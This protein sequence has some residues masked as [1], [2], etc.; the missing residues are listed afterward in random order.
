M[1]L[2]QQVTSLDL[3]KRLKELGVKQESLFFWVSKMRHEN[4]GEGFKRT[5]DVWVIERFGEVNPSG[6]GHK[7]ASA[8]T[9]AELGEVLPQGITTYCTNITGKWGWKSFYI[10][11]TAISLDEKFDTEADARAKMLICLL[12]NDLVRLG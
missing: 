9:V 3:S 1:K 11:T 7:W 12:E 10:V 4:N 6:N 8:F 2:E 5:E